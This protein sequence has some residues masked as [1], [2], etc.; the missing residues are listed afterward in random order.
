MTLPSLIIIAALLLALSCRAFV[1]AQSST[2]AANATTTSGTL[3]IPPTP[4]PVP[5]TTAVDNTIQLIFLDVIMEFVEYEWTY[6]QDQRYWPLLQA[7]CGLLP[8]FNSTVGRLECLPGASRFAASLS[9]VATPQLLVITCRAFSG[10]GYVLPYAEDQF[11]MTLEVRGTIAKIQGLIDL[12]N[13]TQSYLPSLGVSRVYSLGLDLAQSVY[14]GPF[15]T[16]GVVKVEQTIAQKA[17]LPAIVLTGVILVVALVFLAVRVRTSDNAA[18]GAGA[19]G[20]DAA[21]EAYLREAAEATASAFDKARGEGLTTGITEMTTVEHFRWNETA[22]TERRDTIV[23]EA[24]RRRRQRSLAGG[25]PRNADD[26][27]SAG[28]TAIAFGEALSCDPRLQLPPLPEQREAAERRRKQERLQRKKQ[29]DSASPD[30]NVESLQLPGETRAE[31]DTRE[32]DEQREDEL[33]NDSGLE[34]EL[35]PDGSLVK[36]DG[37]HGRLGG[38]SGGSSGGNTSFAPM[39]LASR[40]IAAQMTTMAM[41]SLPG[42]M[43]PQRQFH[44]S[45]TS[46]LA[47]RRLTRAAEGF[48]PLPPPSSESTDAEISFGPPRRFDQASPTSAEGSP[49]PIAKRRASGVPPPTTRLVID[50]ELL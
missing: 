14:T 20:T 44:L 2:T 46:P 26:D 25:A 23:D 11:L 35:P 43:A 7:L 3:S 5:S 31:R 32:A 30:A 28:M 34:F 24:L 10:G 27:A 39:G 18:G 37:K 8:S 17:G 16:I 33:P 47:S 19:I 13:V 22:L 1:I 42:A 48:V 12:L 29:S 36:R 50:D 6:G 45:K 41:Q 21:A 4:S 38:S 15:G 40:R 49:D 9:P